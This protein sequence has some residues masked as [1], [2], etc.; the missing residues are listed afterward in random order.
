MLAA[1]TGGSDISRV[2]VFGGSGFLGSAIVETLAASGYAVRVAC[3]N[4]NNPT[5]HLQVEQY[6]EIL[7]VDADVSDKASISAA[8]KDCD[9][10]IN[11][12]GLYVES[13]TETFEAV[14]EIGAANIAHQASTLG[15]RHLIHISGIGVNLSSKSHYVRARAKGELLVQ[16]SFSKATILRPSAIFGTQ[17]AFLNT[18]ASIARRTPILPLFGRGSTR[19]QPVYV[20]DVADAVISVL[21]DINASGQIFELGGPQIY[22]YRDLINLV[23]THTERRCLLL[24]VPFAIWELLAIAS[25]VLQRPPLTMAQVTLMRQDNVVAEGALTFEDLGIEPMPIEDVLPRY[26][27]SESWMTRTTSPRQ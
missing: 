9:A 1:M 13:E 17:D 16:G 25:S 3:R 11:A 19:L 8:L 18:L 26:G 4:S 20:G 24:P 22:S 27:F 10:V 6:A 23:L 15:V 14:H 5:T 21:G 2:T 7:P 12:V